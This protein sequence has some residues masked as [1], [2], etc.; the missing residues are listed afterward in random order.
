MYLKELYQHHKGWFVVVIL[1]ATAQLVNNIRQDISLSPIYLYGMYSAYIS[2]NNMHDVFEIDINGKTLQAKDFS[3]QQWDNIILPLKYYSNS[4][5]NNNNMYANDIKRL[6]QQF[7]IT[8]DSS[9]FIYPLD[10]NRFM[11]WY[12]S[13]LSSL[14]K[15]KVDSLQISYSLYKFDSTFH[16]IQ[17]RPFTEICN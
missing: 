15:K 1:F 16:K 12:K 17:S 14:L 13:Y 2:P 3:P 6:L 5:G 4:A 7:H 11:I 10:K 8:A 9:K